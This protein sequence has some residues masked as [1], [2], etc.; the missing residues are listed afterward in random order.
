M[1]EHRIFLASRTA[2]REMWEEKGTSGVESMRSPHWRPEFQDW[3]ETGT[4][5]QMATEA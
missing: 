5:I 1:A 4:T 2:F 3:G